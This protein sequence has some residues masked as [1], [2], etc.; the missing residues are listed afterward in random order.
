M[1]TLESQLVK[2]DLFDR[3][4]EQQLA[5]VAQLD[6]YLEQIRAGG[7]E[8]YVARHRE[9]G[10]LLARE[11]IELLVDRDAPFLELMPFAAGHTDFEIGASVIVGIGVVEGVECMIVAHDPTI[12]GGA[13]NPWT[14]RKIFRALDISRENRLPFINIVE[15]GGADLPTQADLFVP[16]GARSIPPCTSRIRRHR[17]SG[18]LPSRP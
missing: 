15:S 2:G 7:G 12:R 18:P 5:L 13:S 17:A 14:F 9:R 6:G 10:K 11:R 4:R 1:I 16:G 3:N 8:K